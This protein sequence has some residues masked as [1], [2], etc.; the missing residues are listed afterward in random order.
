VTGTVTTA[1]PATE[2]GNSDASKGFD[3]SIEGV[4][5][6]GCSRVSHFDEVPFVP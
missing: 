5:V 2:S 3:A 6:Q 4:G 1:E